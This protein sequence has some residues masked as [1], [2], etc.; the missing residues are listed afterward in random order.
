M[1][2]IGTDIIKI[3]RM[4]LNYNFISKVL[5]QDEQLIYNS[6][7]SKKRKKEFL[8]GRWAAKES[9]IK[10]LNTPIL[11][12]NINIGYI[13]EKPTILNDN[14]KSIEL[15][16]SHDNKYCIAVAILLELKEK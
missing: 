16:I 4:K 5:H 7:I 13:N 2:K 12:S 9:I 11:M 1:Y 8:A 15:S 6:F 3:K 10:I 14:L